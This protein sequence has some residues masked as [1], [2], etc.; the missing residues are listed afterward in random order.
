ML[1]FSPEVQHPAIRLSHAVLPNK[2]PSIL[3][4]NLGFDDVTLEAEEVV[5]W[6]APFEESDEETQLPWEQK[7]GGEGLCQADPVKLPEPHP[8]LPLDQQSQIRTLLQKFQGVFA[9]RDEE[10][11]RSELVEHTINVQ[12]PPIR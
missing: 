10:V 9:Q 11:G 12:G 2:R 3:V 7:T 6:G 1:V 5:G 4:A 8:E